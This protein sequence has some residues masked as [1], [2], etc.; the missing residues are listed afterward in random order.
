MYLLPRLCNRSAWLATGL[1]TI[2]DYKKELSGSARERRHKQQNQ[3]V[4]TPSISP[5]QRV[6][7]L[8]TVIPNYTVKL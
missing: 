1:A 4:T 3:S 7:S 8:L 6:Q 5:N 2:H